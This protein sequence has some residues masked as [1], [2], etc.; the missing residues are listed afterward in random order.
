MTLLLAGCATTAPPAAPWP[1]APPMV[2]APADAPPIQA[3][4]PHADHFAHPE[5]HYVG[6][7]LGGVFNRG[8]GD[9]F[10][11]GLD[12]EY[13]WNRHWGAGAFLHAVAVARNSA[14]LG[15]HALYHATDRLGLV[16]GAGVEIPNHGPT[17]LLLR[18]GANYEFVAGEILAVPGIY[19]DVIEGGRVAAVLGITFMHKP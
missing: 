5:G 4:E 2:I 14:V 16:A 1:A 3:S 13:R 6:I 17:E 19:L 12:Y 11:F 7:F 18:F 8:I 9:G 10:T 15:A